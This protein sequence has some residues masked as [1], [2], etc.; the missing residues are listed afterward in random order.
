MMILASPERRRP[1]FNLAALPCPCC[2]PSL[3]EAA[4]RKRA[5]VA[6]ASA[7]RKAAPRK[8]IARRPAAR[9]SP[10]RIDVHHHIAPPVYLEALG[11]DN[12]YNGSEGSRRATLDWSPS[13]AI[14]DMDAGGTEVAITSLYAASALAAHP[15]ARRIARACNEFAVRMRED[16]PGRFGGFATLPIDRK[17][18]RL[19][20]S[21]SQ[22]SR[23]PSSA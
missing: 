6:R 14:E 16:Y 22:Q 15:E 5:S 10:R 18:T 7:T 19:N 1:A 20:S 23:M 4:T 11:A 17:S 2:V 8:K 9:P 21:H 13:M 12:L 3:L